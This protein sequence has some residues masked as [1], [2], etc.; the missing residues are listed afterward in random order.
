AE[1]VSLRMATSIFTQ[2]ANGEQEFYDL[3]EDPYQ[4]ENRISEI[5]QQ[6]QEKWRT[7]MRELK[8]G[9]HPPQ[10]TLA[11][12][13]KFG[14]HEKIRGFVD[15]DS[16]IGSVQVQ[17]HHNEYG[18]WN[19]E[20]WNHQSAWLTANLENPDG[21]LSGWSVNCRYEQFEELTD[22]RVVAV[23]TDRAGTRSQAAKSDYQ[24]DVV[25]PV[26][27]L[28]LPE[29]GSTVGVKTMLFGTA[30]DDQMLSGIELTLIRLDDGKFYDG[31]DW[32][33]GE[34]TFL[35]RLRQNRW[36]RDLVL[37]PGRYKASAR[38]IDASGNYDLTPSVTEFSVT[39][40]AD[41]DE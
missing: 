13:K 3:V 8:R 34:T 41:R 26:A 27:I 4:L 40:A 22:I 25:D 15:V 32:V 19:G 9:G 20:K 17:I 1:Y 18:Y 24:V 38:A 14:R 2:W 16:A 36:H 39:D 12:Q 31:V 21:L 6:Q 30:S 29:N 5:S 11:N 37:A 28:K 23:A 33:D 35:K 7:R 10:V